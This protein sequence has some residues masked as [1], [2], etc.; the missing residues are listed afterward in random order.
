M[1]S[2]IIFIPFMPKIS[3]LAHRGMERQHKTAVKFTGEK[4]PT[5][6]GRTF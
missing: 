2:L 3:P 4:N 6:T 5:H 1:K